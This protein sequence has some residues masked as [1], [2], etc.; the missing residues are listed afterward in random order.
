[1][2]TARARTASPSAISRRNGSLAAPAGA[3]AVEPRDLERDGNLGA[4]LLR[5]VERPPRQRLA[6]NAGGEAEIVLDAR[7]GAG[8]PADRALVEHDDRKSFRRAI[9]RGGKT[10]GTGAHHGD[11]VDRARIELRRDAEAHAGFGVARTLE[12]RAVGTDHQRQFVRLDAEALHRGARFFVGNGVKHGVGIA[13]AREEALQPDE[14]GRTA[15]VD[16]QR[17]GAAIL[18]AARRGAG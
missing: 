15:A 11:I 18:D 5:L 3:A 16:Q 17:T 10:G 7:R 1:M 6:G 12:Q 8:L 9:D 14:F 4:E 13:V 2:T